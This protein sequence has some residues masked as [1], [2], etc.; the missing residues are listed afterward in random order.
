MNR[1]ATPP[2]QRLAVVFV[3]LTALLGVACAARLAVGT[4]GVG[5]PAWDQGFL[6]SAQIGRAHV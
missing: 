4:T 2:R 6:W 1:A 3:A 5:L